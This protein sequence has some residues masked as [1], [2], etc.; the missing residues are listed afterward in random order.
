MTPAKVHLAK[1]ALGKQDTV[2]NELRKELGIG[3]QTLYRYV[4]A[5]GALRANGKKLLKKR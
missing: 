4:S 1:A 5:A 3:R 2:V